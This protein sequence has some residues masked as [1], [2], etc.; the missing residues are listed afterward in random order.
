MA[1]SRRKS[2]K[3]RR[4]SKKRVF[5]KKST[6]RPSA[7]KK[8][9]KREIARS[10]ENK[11]VQTYNLGLPIRSVI[12][13]SFGSQVIQVSPC[14]TAL[15]VNQGTGQGARIGN[16][17]TIKK[18]RFK[19]TI[20]PQVYS[21]SVNP[22][23]QPVQIKMFLF[24]DKLAAPNDVI[25]PQSSNDFFQFGS[26]TTG[27]HNDL[28]DMWAPVNTDK[29]RV[30]TTRSFKCGIASNNGTGYVADA[31]A[32]NNNDF[33][34]NCNFSIDLTPY[35]IKH[36]KYNDNSS[37]PSTRSLYCMF[38]PCYAGGGAIGGSIT[39]A[40]TQ[41]MLDMEYEDA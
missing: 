32:Y 37:D 1:F 10:I 33:K 14:A 35:V 16:N 18:L 11:S 28:I 13:G 7:L 29:Y 2:S 36:V 8:M 12:H 23:P 15:A 5:K 21:A 39:A 34:L 3:N 22:N 31:Q 20:V 6:R 24:Y 4:V 9:V 26:T 25:N 17:I 27:F 38:V 40:G 30:L 19:G 41:F